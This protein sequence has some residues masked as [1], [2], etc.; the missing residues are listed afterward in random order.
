[1]VP[2]D[3]NN[4]PPEPSEAGPT[5]TFTVPEY[6]PEPVLRET[7]PAVEFEAPEAITTLPELPAKDVPVRTVMFPLLPLAEDPENI[8][9]APEFPTVP[10]AVARSTVPVPMLELAPLYRNTLPP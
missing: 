4:C 3:N 10:L 6:T 9:T 5:M 7:F 1:V 2:A 8:W